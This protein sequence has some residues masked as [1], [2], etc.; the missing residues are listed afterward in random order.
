MAFKPKVDP[1]PE[2]FLHLLHKEELSVKGTAKKEHE[3]PCGNKFSEE[4]G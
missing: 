4:G 3:Y 1:V 2:V